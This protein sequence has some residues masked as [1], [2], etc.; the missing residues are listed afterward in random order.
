MGND[1]Q[2]N[3]CL[4]SSPARAGEKGKQ[5]VLLQGAQQ[6]FPRAGG[7]TEETLWLLC[8]QSPSQSRVRGARGRPAWNQSHECQKILS[9]PHHNIAI[10]N[11]H[12]LSLCLAP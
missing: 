10:L 3:C 9:P 7:A 12:H 11:K 4:G 1:S 2:L 5:K 8:Y 6:L